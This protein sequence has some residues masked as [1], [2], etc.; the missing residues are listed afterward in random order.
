[1]RA[2]LAILATTA[3]A[4]V[5]GS[6]WAQQPGAAPTSPSPYPAEMAIVVPEVEVRSGP[7]RE[8]YPTSKLT[9]G[10]RVIVLRESK[11]QP[12]WVAIKPPQGSFSWV[13][14]KN[15]AAVDPRTGYVVD[16]NE[17]QVLPGSGL[18]NREPNVE[19]ARIKPGH[20]VVLLDR[21]MTVGQMTWY[22]IAPVP[23]EV[24]WIP[25]DAVRP[26]QT[27]SAWNQPQ[28]WGTQQPFANTSQ[29]QTVLQ[30]ADQALQAGN[31][32]LARQLYKEAS[33]KTQDFNQRQYAQ[34]RLSQMPVSAW[35]P[36]ALAGNPY[37]PIQN[38]QNLPGGVKPLTPGTPTSGSWTQPGVGNQPP[39]VGQ[40]GFGTQ[41]PLSGSTPPPQWSGWGTLKR[42]A[43][44]KDGQPLF[45]LENRQGQAMM[46][47][48][49]GTGTSLRDYVNRVI[50]LYGPVY[51]QN[52]A[53]SRLPYMVASHIAQQ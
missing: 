2:I 21:P 49:S 5:V 7:T 11:D 10:Q 51:N 14:S 28:P 13:N 12:G 46:Y 52:D 22:P 23:T 16:G 6:S 18:V 50:C 34:T 20:L 31:T 25:V 15:V 26:V 48:T 33:E 32:E 42:T 53:A 45:V 8:Y 47:V 9:Y 38:N 37:Q 36:G 24:R 35:N 40:P 17:V 29:V 1:M 3:L 39:L 4:G 43:M 44:D 41:P 19:S 27:T 30:Q